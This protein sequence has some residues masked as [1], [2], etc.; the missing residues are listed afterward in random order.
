M[1]EDI[2]LVGAS[3]HKLDDSTDLQLDEAVFLAVSDALRDAGVKRHQ[4][5][6]SITSS[7]DLYDGRS[8]SSA[9]TAPA[10][11]A[12]L[13]DEVR[14]EG[15]SV[16]AFL[17]AAAGIASNQADFAVAVAI[18]APEAGSTTEPVVR[19]LREQISSYTFD[20]HFDRPIG[21]SSAVTLGM[22][23]AAAIDSGQAD[24]DAMARATAEEINRGAAFGRSSRGTTTAEAVKG[25]APAA[26]PLTELM[27]PAETAGVGAVVLASGM[28]GR[29][30]PRI[31][32]RLTGWGSATGL[33]TWNPAWLRNPTE[34]ASRAATEAYTRAGLTPDRIAHLE[35]TDL[36][37]ALTAPLREAL[38]AGHLSAEAINHKGGVR[39]NHPGIG[40]GLL[41]V[42]EATEALG[43]DGAAVVHATDDLMGL[44]S[45]TTSVLVLEAP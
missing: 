44:V 3:W 18:N 11:A 29:R 40:A 31:R 33:P 17:I 14:I 36:S 12:Y 41:R 26:A 2:Y 43:D 9:L 15:D 20:S 4:V 19:R 32:A 30:S 6:L 21:M 23:A 38:Q 25:S 8:I 22:H 39:S 10:A 45:A 5:E 13:N 27:L 35:M 34:A 37:P 42:I 28:S 1:T 24:F 16:A 7:L